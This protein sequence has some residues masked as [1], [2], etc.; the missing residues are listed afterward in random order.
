MDKDPD[1]WNWSTDD[2]IDEFCKSRSVWIIGRPNVKLPDPIK[3]ES[4]LRD[5][6]VDGA[7]ILEIGHE[8]LKDDLDIKPF[9]HRDG[10]MW[11]IDQLRQRSVKWRERSQSKKVMQSQISLTNGQ[12]PITPFPLPGMPW[13]VQFPLPT[14]GHS[15]VRSHE[16]IEDG[17]SQLACIPTADELADQNFAS[18][19]PEIAELATAQRRAGETLVFDEAG[20]KRRRLIL[21]QPSA[22]TPDKTIKQ[23]IEKSS[24]PNYFQLPSRSVLSGSTFQSRTYLGPTKFTLDDVFFSSGR[25]GKPINPEWDIRPVPESDLDEPDFEFVVRQSQAIPGRQKYVHS[26]LVK[27]FQELPYEHDSV[28]RTVILSPYPPATG[29]AESSRSVILF[30]TTES[31]ISATRERATR[32]DVKDPTD[33]DNGSNPSNHDWDFLDHW[34][35]EETEECPVYGESETNSE[36]DR[37]FESIEEEEKADM[38]QELG[39]HRVLGK[40]QVIAVIEEEIDQFT[41]QWTAQKLPLRKNLAWSTWRKPKGSRARLMEAAG[42]RGQVEMLSKRL[43]K[44]KDSILDEVW[45]KKKKIR[46]LCG[47]LQETVFQREEHKFKASVWLQNEAPLRPVAELRI[48]KKARITYDSDPDAID[49][50]G[51]D[52]VDVSDL[53]DRFIDV[54]MTGEVD[55]SEEHQPLHAPYQENSDAQSG[56]KDASSISNNVTTACERDEPSDAQSSAN[57]KSEPDHAP[58]A[59]RLKNQTSSSY[60]KNVIDLTMSD[61]DFQSFSNNPLED[62]AEKV[63]KWKW[64]SLIERDDRKRLIIKLLRTLPGEYYSTLRKPFIRRQRLNMAAEIEIAAENVVHRFEGGSVPWM[65]IARLYCCWLDCSPELFERVKMSGQDGFKAQMPEHKAQQVVSACRQGRSDVK[66]FCGFVHS[67]F[68][69]YEKPTSWESNERDLPT[70]GGDSDGR[71]VIEIPDTPHKKRKKEIKESQIGIQKRKKVMRT[72]EEHEKRSRAFFTAENSELVETNDRIVVNIGKKE[73]EEPVYLNHH[74]GKR[75]QPH[76]IEGLRF[77]WREVV[78]SSMDEHDMQGCLLAHTMG[79]GKT[80]QV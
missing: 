26:Q 67:V 72:L 21:G 11:G 50:S 56:S 12:T 23:P 59:D 25:F 40:D 27:F 14:N 32:F 80:M 69:L 49:L 1:P 28:G 57:V 78:S 53:G 74:I 10:L 48:K 31:G 46:G 19:K 70:A 13:P 4:A 61:D 73:E 7:S 64:D 9:G 52:V 22:L 43:N 15:P 71:V 36:L 18:T 38:E 51:S 30:Q 20:R 44:L 16:R 65:D 24:N 33:C 62:S 60:A 17:R 55:A 2:V 77:M 39:K 41:Q 5:N 63:L 45:Y 6:E 8:Q 66:E 76:Q 42:A 3:L 54:D 79:L 68:E 35:N 34:R 47:S 29:V 75:I 37:C 58:L